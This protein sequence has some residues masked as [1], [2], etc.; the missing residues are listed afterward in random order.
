MGAS[1]GAC[2]RSRGRPAPQRWAPGCA[3]S[4]RLMSAMTGLVV[5]GV[6]QV[7]ITAFVELQRLVGGAGARPL[8][9]P[10]PDRAKPAG[11]GAEC[12]T[13]ALHVASRAPTPPSP[14]ALTI[15][16]PMP[17]TSSPG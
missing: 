12:R 5:D 14:I 11:F 7:L 4:Q 2:G 8:T 16:R 1:K 17:G 9:L 3:A 15:A 6:E 10:L 13:K